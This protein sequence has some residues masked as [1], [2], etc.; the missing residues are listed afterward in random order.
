MELKD[1][2]VLM[3]HVLRMVRMVM[4]V[5]T[6]VMEEMVLLIITISNLN[7]YKIK[8]FFNYLKEVM[9]INY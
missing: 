1:L 3:Q 4:M 5:A 2:A 8:I 7:I 6:E 9:V